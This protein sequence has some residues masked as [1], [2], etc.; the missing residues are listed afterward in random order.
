MTHYGFRLHEMTLR[1]GRQQSPVPF[2]AAGVTPES[3]RH[4]RETL[5]HLLANLEGKV[6]I[7]QPKVAS[8]EGAGVEVDDSEPVHRDLLGETAFRFQS[9]R[10]SEGTIV[11]V[12][13]RGRYGSHD[14]AMGTDD[15]TADL[16]LTGRAPSTWFR[17][18][19]NLPTKGTTAVLAI[20]DIGRSC[21]VDLMLK[22]LA[23]RSRELA[24]QHPPLATGQ[25]AVPWWRLMARQVTDPDHLE[26]LLRSG[27][28]GEVRL[29]K[30]L[31]TGDRVRRQRAYTVTS[32]G[33]SEGRLDDLKQT[34]LGWRDLIGGEA[35][36]VSD[37]EGA[38]QLAA[39]IAP[40]LIG[41]D[42][43]DGEI[44]LPGTGGRAL[45]PSRLGELFTYDQVP[46]DR[47]S[48]G[49]AFYR[50]IR[51]HIARLNA[52]SPS[53]EAGLEWPE[54]VDLEFPEVT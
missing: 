29:I 43:A 32:P 36:S 23:Q 34:V 54:A 14:L 7:G 28:F 6:L 35:P 3:P 19:L 45:K 52:I 33:V 51:G 24:E 31:D 40:E 47:R 22:W 16:P 4:F 13:R 27:A 38:Q 21:P 42:F 30:Q 5:L 2:E 8:A 50:A 48:S 15:T 12:V 11:G 46:S 26:G 1:R 17:Y 53:D 18:V 39:L 44:A 41:I 20:E 25:S 10:Q 37:A 49:V 9:H